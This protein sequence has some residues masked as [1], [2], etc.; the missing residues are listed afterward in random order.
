LPIG[1]IG[2]R[3][4][5]LSSFRNFQLVLA[6]SYAQEAV[7]PFSPS[8]TVKQM[9]FY[10]AIKPAFWGAVVGAVAMAIV[11]FSWLGWTL[12]STAEQ[13]A[14]TRAEAATV[15]ALAPVCVARFEAQ[16]DAPTRLTELRKIL[17]S[18][19][20]ASFIEKGGWATTPGSDKPNSAVAGACAQILGKVT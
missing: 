15:A 10:P 13:L 3:S 4:L 14:N 8:A 2:S 18:W 1:A 17:T 19:D 12:G 9:T 6:A 7:K 5:G 16:A 11:G 20:Q